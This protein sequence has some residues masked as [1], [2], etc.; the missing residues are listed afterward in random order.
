MKGIVVYESKYGNTK[1]VAEKI[2]EGIKTV[3]PMEIESKAQKEIKA[4]RVAPYDFIA[5]GSPVRF[6]KATRGIRKFIDR[7]GKLDLKEKK[8]FLFDTYLGG[9]HMKGVRSMEKIINEKVRGIGLADEGLSVKVEGMRGPLVEGA[10]EECFEY[11]R[12]MASK[13]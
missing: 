10:L 9:D 7:V 1:M 8:G 3:K 6:G 5:F 2:I 11:G 13:L 12:K 4:E